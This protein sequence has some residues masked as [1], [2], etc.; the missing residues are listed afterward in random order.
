[1]EKLSSKEKYYFAKQLSSILDSSV[2]VMEGLELMKDGASLKIKTVLEKLDEEYNRSKSLSKA[3]KEADV[4]D[5]YFVKMS[6]LG[7]LNGSLD[8]VMKELSS[9]Y[10]KQ[11]DF[12]ERV[13]DSLSQPFTL[14]LMMILISAVIVFKIYPVFIDILLKM[15]LGVNDNTLIFM[16]LARYI[17]VVVMVISIVMA[18]F[19]L[20][21][22]YSDN[23][24]RVKILNKIPF[25]KNI[26]LYTSLYKL[27]S[28][29]LMMVKSGYPLNEGIRYLKDLVD[30]KEINNKL[31]IIIESADNEKSFDKTILESDLFND[32]AVSILKIGLKTGHPI[33]AYES[34]ESLYLK[35]SDEYTERLLNRIEPVFIGILS[36]VVIVIVLSVMLPLLNISSLLA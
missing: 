21:F 27:S 33:E 1:M 20:V 12:E 10:Y 3:I 23:S 4:F 31:E 9:F 5:D 8:N 29:I 19:V 26:S 36:V 15:G 28:G 18:V 34:L 25:M 32:E 2:S 17:G 7:E 35:K 16:K 14:L 24:K 30:N 6:E 13:K 11:N 22:M